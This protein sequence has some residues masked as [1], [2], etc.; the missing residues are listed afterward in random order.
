MKFPQPIARVTLTRAA[1]LTVIA[2][3]ATVPAAEQAVDAA[4]ANINVTT[5]DSV[6]F[7][8]ANTTPSI[9]LGTVNGAALPAGP[10]PGWAHTRWTFLKY[11]GA[12]VVDIPA[13]EKIVGNA[14][15]A[16]AT[17]SSTY[18]DSAAASTLSA[19][20][21]I[22][23]VETTRDFLIANGSTLDIAKGGLLFHSN[24]HWL[25]NGT[26]GGF[27]TSSS[28]QLVV[29]ANGSG[30]DYQINTIAIKD[31]NGTTPL[32]L[33]KTGPDHL[34]LSNI[35]NTY[36][37]G[38]FINNG[39]LRA[40][41]IA[42]YGAASG[43]VR[44]SGANS[45]ACL[46]AAGN[47][48]QSFEA[49]GL[50][51]SETSGDKLGAIRFEAAANI[52]GSVTLTAPAR[53]TV[54]NGVSGAINGALIGN[55][56]LQLG[57]TGFAGTLNLNGSGTGM[58]APVAVAFGRLNVNN[59]LGGSATVSGGA[60]L[61]GE[62]TIA[63][64]LT[65]GGP[66]AST[67]HVDGATPATLAVGGAVD[68]SPGNTTIA[69]VGANAS[70]FTAF[71]YGSLTGPVAN[72]S[73]SGVRGGTAS[74]D[75][76][77]SRVQV[78]Y[79]PG[80]LTWTGTANANWTQNA[81][82]NFDNGAPT[83]FFNGDHVNF[84]DDAAVK[85]LTLV[86]TLYPGSV[87]FTNDTDYTV[88]GANAGISGSTGITK[89]GSGTVT[90]NG[91]SS[92][93]TGPVIVNAGR[94]KYGTFWGSLGANS[95]VT[96]ASGAQVDFNGCSPAGVGRN[97]DWTIAGNGPDGLGAITN[98]GA[99]SIQENAGI[100]SVTLTA[101]ASI[102]GNAGRL[103]L[104]N[105]AGTGTITG[106]GHTL[107]KVGTAPVGFRTNASGSPVNFV[108]AAGK[109]W[110]ENTNAAWG[111]ATGTLRVKNAAAAGTYGT[112]SIST[113][114]FLEAGS[115]LYNEGG[116]KGTWTA[117][118][119]LEGDATVDAV[120]GAMDLTGAVSGAFALTKSGGN[121]LLLSNNQYTGNTTVT[122]GV[123]T[124]SAATLGDGSTVSI[125]ATAGTKLDLPHGQPD[126]V[127]V[128][129][130]GG[131]PQ[132]PGTYG[133][134]ASAATHKDDT[135]F[136][137]TGMLNVSSAGN[138][139]QT[140][141]AANGIGGASANTDSDNDGISNGIE[142]VI[143]GTPNG[144]A[145]TALLPTFNNSDPV[146]F[147]FVFRRT[148]DS[149]SFNPYVEY[150][151]NLSGW[152]TA[153]PGEPEANPVLIDETDDFYGEGIDRVTVRIPKA[154]AAGGIRLF[155]RLRVDIP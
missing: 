80:T 93:F 85:T 19:S 11:D 125:A 39:R 62:S 96:V 32:T 139:Y 103:D 144:P 114:V 153:E 72:L 134:T 20:Q 98:S 133:S 149:A 143:G 135:R 30:T 131:V 99:A 10:L 58:T 89:N 140:W 128:L 86:G 47:F 42:S 91:Q 115:K 100:R 105:A 54:N 25:K 104:G 66:T 36:T 81:D 16:T 59:G 51:W 94:L 121:A 33:V 117:A 15:L 13:A 41:N 148:E 29:V 132:V 142:F 5:G 76:A 129:L 4:T 87:T 24:N 71:T 18:Y 65:I 147:D 78:S 120:N 67:L 61:G 107:T 123:L 52:A 95:G 21:S 17:A 57:F 60:A 9:P 127:S 119:T 68:L 40:S 141:A 7:D 45:Q 64:G 26:G 97:Y 73:V 14:L 92:N 108:I 3:T 35:A 63:G 155:A 138:D 75:A 34:N 70:P 101:D 1:L 77:N 112:R 136:S 31:F 84:T 49:S 74:D 154:L 46:A 146:Y 106:N 110:G 152:T 53:I 55:S 109:A 6:W 50:G 130:I 90:L 122:A 23:L 79:T 56:M 44:V 2:T 102:G 12:N 126:T 145:D 113:P 83:N 137:G 151:S 43:V 48:G 116:G 38:T 88:L 37:G 69:V 28:G 118:V 8:S 124:L 22:G 111:G 27:I 82:L 150:G